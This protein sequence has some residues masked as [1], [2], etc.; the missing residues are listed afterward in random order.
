MLKSRDRG[1]LLH[2]QG[3]VALDISAGRVAAERNEGGVQ[4]VGVRVLVRAALVG[5]AVA[6][7]AAGA[8]GVRR[9]LRARA[10]VANG[11]A[12]MYGAQKVVRKKEG[13]K[14]GDM[15]DEVGLCLRCLRCRRSRCLHT[16]SR[17]C[18]RPG[19]RRRRRPRHRRRC[20]PCSTAGCSR[21][22]CRCTWCRS[23]PRCCRRCRLRCRGWR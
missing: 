7:T 23:T 5:G 14:N 4:G 10:A 22:S 13:A 9:R 2:R 6:G 20:R 17:W 11:R 8:A 15:K 16:R 18:C 12:L 1:H 3:L 19:S 21:R